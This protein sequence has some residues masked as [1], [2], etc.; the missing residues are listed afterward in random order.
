MEAGRDV[1]LVHGGGKHI[2][3][4]MAQLGLP[5]RTHAGLRITDDAT[6]DVVV[7]VLGGL[8]TS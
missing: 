2:D 3:A 4:M 5:K 1:V 7:A 8:S 6:L